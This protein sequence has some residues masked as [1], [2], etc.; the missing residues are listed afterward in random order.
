MKPAVLTVALTLVA[1][2][3]SAQM[4]ES[5][6]NGGYS[7][8]KASDLSKHLFVIASDEYQGRETSME[9]QKM[10]AKYI[11]G[12]FRSLGLRPVGDDGTY[13]QHFDVEVTQLDGKNSSVMVDG[14]MFDFGKD[15]STMSQID[16]TLTAT[17]V[18][19]GFADSYIDP[20][21]ADQISGKI[22]ITF[23]GT[24]KQVADTS[25]RGQMMRLFAS[26]RD[27]GVFAA[28][29]IMDP[30]GPASFESLTSRFGSAPRKSMRRADV[31]SSS[32]RRGPS[33][34]R[35]YA[36]TELSHTLFSA[37][38]SSHDEL[39][40]T[41]MADSTFTPIFLDDE[42]IT[43]KNVVAK[44]IRRTE[45]VLGFL[46][47]SDPALKDEVVVLTAHYDH[48]GITAD[49]TVYNGADDDGSGTVT[50][51]ELAEAFVENGAR[52]KRSMLFMTVT[53]EEK[54]LLGSAHYTDNPVFPL[55]KTVANLN[56]DMIGRIGHSY[57]EKNDSLYVYV[58]GSDKISKDLDT[59]LREANKQ[60]VGLHLDYTY[61]DDKDPN[62][63][64]YRS[65]HYNFAKNGVPV[66]FFFTGT[67][68]DYHRPTDTPDKILYE[69]MAMIARLIYATAWKVADRT[70]GL[71][72]NP[73]SAQ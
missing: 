59:I 56:I 67:H 73:P 22:V 21:Y 53:G 40:K 61:N 12:H 50:V 71:T 60:T 26:R 31:E 25:E 38:G 3:A 54:G 66:T 47:G 7:S 5:A 37:A 32:R 4:K 24:R 52:P 45:N 14:Q 27:P 72:K 13:F 23:A 49:G 8:I 44:E 17:A 19:L 20:S 62:R 30:E 64:Y 63:F 35:V 34:L 33:T 43:I 36:S 69:R 29:T 46:E 58:I 1:T 11:A 57:M 68:P 18:F 16:T 70:S 48:D 15:Y 51:L 55:D 9:G 28:I 39:W 65:D 10:A 6:A 41:A 42:A 2:F